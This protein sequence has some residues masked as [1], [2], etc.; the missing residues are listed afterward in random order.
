MAS[1]V[2][3]SRGGFEDFRPRPHLNDNVGQGLQGF[4]GIDGSARF[5]CPAA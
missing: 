2:Q 1:V 4:G 3:G 5:G